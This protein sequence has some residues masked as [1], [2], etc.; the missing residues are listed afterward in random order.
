[1]AIAAGLMWAVLRP[2]QEDPPA[3]YTYDEWNR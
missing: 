3:P 2:M 1:M